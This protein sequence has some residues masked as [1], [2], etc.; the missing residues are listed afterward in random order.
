MKHVFVSLCVCETAY[1]GGGRAGGRASAHWLAG[2]LHLA[3]PMKGGTGVEHRSTLGH[4]IQRP[5]LLRITSA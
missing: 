1:T 3:V 2:A 4:H 5:H